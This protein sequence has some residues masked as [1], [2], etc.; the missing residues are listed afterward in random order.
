MKEFAASLIVRL[1]H[2][3]AK[4]EL[5]SLQRLGAAIG[6]LIWWLQLKPARITR[7]NLNFCYP[8]ATPDQCRDLGR[9]SMQD[10]VRT[11]VEAGAIWEWPL[12]RSLA[13]VREV[14]GEELIRESLEKGRGV[15]VLGPHLGNWELTGLYLAS[16]FRMAS[17]YRPPRLQGLENYMRKARSRSGAEL[18]PTTNKGVARL[19]AILRDGGVVGILPDQVPP[20]E[21]S[22]FAPFFGLETSTM[23]LA[24]RLSARTG[25]SVLCAYALRLPNAQGFRLIIKPADGVEAP[26]LKSSL[27]A[28]NRCVEEGISLEPSQYQWEYRRFKRRP[29][30]LPRIYYE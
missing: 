16:K 7:T 13:L 28:L 6:D 9:R 27:T 5:R 4:L 26:D 25:A 23:T 10:T 15:I 29:K 24:S 1:A 3:L 21:S 14:E 20:K 19:L 18:V 8:R 11:I 17:L 30:G 2:W 12:E 22:D